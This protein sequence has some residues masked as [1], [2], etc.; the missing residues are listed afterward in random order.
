MKTVEEY[1]ADY[2][3]RL[4]NILKEN[5]KNKEELNKRRISNFSSD[6]EKKLD[7]ILYSIDRL[8]GILDII[9]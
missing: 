1:L 6:S 3:T 9:L 8:F 7:N 4:E 5:E 2:E